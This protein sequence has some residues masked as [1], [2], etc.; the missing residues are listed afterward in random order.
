MILDTRELSVQSVSVGDQKW[1]FKIGD[2]GSKCEAL[3]NPLIITF[4]N[5]LEGAVTIDIRYHTTEKCSALQWL[6][7]EQTCGGKHPYLFS[8]CQAIHAR[9]LFPC[10]DSPGI[11]VKYTAV[12]NVA[13]PLVALMSANLLHDKTVRGERVNTFHFSQHVPMSTYLVAIAAGALESREI[14]PR[15]R[16]WSEVEM[17]DKAAFEFAET[18]DFIKTGEGRVSNRFFSSIFSSQSL[19]RFVL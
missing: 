16:V 9:S 14:G 4:P 18:E 17:V 10:Q 19:E 8:Q 5:A 6:T 3:G 2:R 7:K 15:S 13:A 1:V 11:K 12:V